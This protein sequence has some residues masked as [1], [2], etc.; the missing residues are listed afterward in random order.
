M[1]KLPR[2]LEQKVHQN[3][4]RTTVNLL[5]ARLKSYLNIYH[6]SIRQLQRFCEGPSMRFYDAAISKASQG[7]KPFQ[8]LSGIPKSSSSVVKSLPGRLS[9]QLSELLKPL[10]SLL[11]VKPAA[12]QKAVWELSGT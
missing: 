8:S 4:S 10:W 6:S 5:K 3:R 12:F 1:R 9:C 7:A 2:W 11:A